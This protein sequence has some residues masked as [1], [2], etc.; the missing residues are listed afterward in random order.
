MARVS[1]KRA[2][3]EEKHAL[4]E[5]S[6][7]IENASQLACT[8]HDTC[9]SL[10]SH[11]SHNCC[12]K[13]ACLPRGGLTETHTEALA[14]KQNVRHSALQLAERDL[15][16]LFTRSADIC[17]CRTDSQP[18]HHLSKSETLAHSQNVRQRAQ[19][20]EDLFTCHLIHLLMQSQPR[21]VNIFFQI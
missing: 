1:V 9:T 5:T 16:N 20:H 15:H 11:P 12:W 2:S 10:T 18:Q 7:K 4:P 19:R 13:L 6:K 14:Q 17:S 21:D 8:T 3:F